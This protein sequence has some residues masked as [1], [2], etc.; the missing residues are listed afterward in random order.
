MA[1]RIHH[2]RLFIFGLAVFSLLAVDSAIAQREGAV[3]Q[4]P[5]TQSLMSVPAA[6]KPPAENTR[7]TLD[8]WAPPDVEA[9]RLPGAE[10]SSCSLQDVVSQAGV[11]VEELVHNLDRFSA[12]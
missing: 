10:A 4:D 3:E 8:P 11:R 1:T 6:V 9:L 2:C 5:Q 12:T 7:G